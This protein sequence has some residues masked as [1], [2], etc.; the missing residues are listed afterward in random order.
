MGGRGRSMNNFVTKINKLE[1]YGAEDFKTPF[2]LPKNIEEANDIARYNYR[3]GIYKDLPKTPDKLIKKKKIKI[4]DLFSNQE[5]VRKST[6]LYF[7]NKK[8]NPNSILDNG[9]RPFVIRSG[10]TNLIID[11]HHR[12]SY[13]KAIGVQSL[14]VQVLDLKD[15]K[16]YYNL[17]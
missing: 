8:L 14:D 13:A 6:L 3:I 17:K 5:V 11:G 9:K 2:A 7:A 15:I 10:S 4:S 12:A 16:N 1:S